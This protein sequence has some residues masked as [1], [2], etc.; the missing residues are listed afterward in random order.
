MF[1]RWIRLSE[2]ARNSIWKP[3]GWFSGL[4]CCDSCFGALHSAF[5]TQFLIFYIQ[6]G[7]YYQLGLRE[8]EDRMQAAV[9]CAAPPSHLQRKKTLLIRAQALRWVSA[10]LCTYPVTFC[11]LVV[12]KLLALDRM[13]LFA[14]FQD[15]F[16]TKAGRILLIIVVVCNVVGGVGNLVAVAYYV[17]SSDVYIK[18]ASTN[19]SAVRFQARELRTKGTIAAAVHLFCELIVLLLVISC[20]LVAGI[21]SNRRIQSSMTSLRALASSGTSSDSEAFRRSMETG[22]RLRRQTVATVAAIF[23]SFLLRVIY[24]VM[25]AVANTLNNSSIQCNNFTDRCSTCYNNYTFMQ[26]WML[27]TPEF[28]YGIMFV[29]QNVALLVALW[30]MTSGKAL[31]VLRGNFNPETGSEAKL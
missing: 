5:W 6:T 31:S 8:Q 14:R 15:E 7:N 22:V 24:N 21:A 28:N 3:Y 4:M 29:A 12:S 30:G 20:F 16:W 11:C 27:Y 25:F 9:S 18:A 19:S 17:E 26:I 23:V 1:V 2:E 10:Y 13:R